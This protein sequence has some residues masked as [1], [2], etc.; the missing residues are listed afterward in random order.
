MGNNK[1]AS[2]C[3]MPAAA[4]DSYPVPGAN[5]ILGRIPGHYIAAAL[6]TLGPATRDGPGH[7]EVLLEAGHAG[8]VRLFIEN[9]QAP[10]GRHTHHYWSAPSCPEPEPAP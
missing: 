5:G 10:H 2:R 1:L 7:R 4:P 3:H 9:K 6:G 8:T